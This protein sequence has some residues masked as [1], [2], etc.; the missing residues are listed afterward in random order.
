[1]SAN[2]ATIASFP[3]LYAYMRLLKVKATTAFVATDVGR[4]L[5]GGTTG[6]TGVIRWYDP[7]LE[8]NGTTGHILVSMAAAD[9]LFD[10]V[11]ETVTATSGTGIATM[12]GAAIAVTNLSYGRRSV[13]FTTRKRYVRASLT[14]SAGGNW[15]N[16]EIYLVNE[17]E[18]VLQWP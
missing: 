9:D 6:D 11:D 16:V 1:V 15:G 7:V 4:T 2:F 12:I 8:T 10:D 14:V 18:D 13:R 17:D 3:V 5:T